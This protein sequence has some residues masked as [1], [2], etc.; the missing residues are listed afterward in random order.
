MSAEVAAPVVGSS[1]N[2]QAWR[3]VARFESS[4]AKLDALRLAGRRGWWRFARGGTVRTVPTSSR[5]C[6]FGCTVGTAE[7]KNGRASLDRKIE[8]FLE[9]FWPLK[10]ISKGLAVVAL[11]P[12]IRSQGTIKRRPRKMHFHLDDARSPLTGFA[13]R[14][15]FDV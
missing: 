9:C 12:C 6:S 8:D 4:L 11:A 14:P 13:Q 3:P 15:A 2:V 1:E 5:V 7:K 10:R